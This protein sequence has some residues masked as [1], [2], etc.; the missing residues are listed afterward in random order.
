[1]TGKRALQITLYVVS[2]FVILTGLLDVF[3]GVDGLRTLDPDLPASY[4]TIDTQMRFLGAIWLGFG[5][6]LIWI[7]PTIEKQTMLF[8]LMMGAIFLGA[9]VGCCHWLL[10]AH[11]QPFLSV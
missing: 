8:R 11:H 2:V 4:R 7:T 10:W 3:G 5:V 6:T 1:M 9:S